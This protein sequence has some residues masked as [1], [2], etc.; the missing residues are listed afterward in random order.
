VLPKLQGKPYHIKINTE[1]RHNK[2][3]DCSPH[4]RHCDNFHTISLHLNL[5]LID[6]Q[7]NEGKLLLVEGEILSTVKGYYANGQG[8]SSKFHPGYK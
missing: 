8:R 1:A 5:S 7:T 4:G 2:P 6:T 3:T